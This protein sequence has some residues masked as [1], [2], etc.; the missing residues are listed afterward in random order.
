MSGK[1][2]VILSLWHV[3]TT[4]N[5]NT[6]ILWKNTQVITVSN[7]FWKINTQEKS[8]KRKKTDNK[9]KRSKI[10][11]I[12][13]TVRKHNYYCNSQNCGTNIVKHGIFA[14][15]PKPAYRIDERHE[16]P[17]NHVT[18]YAD[19][20]FKYTCIFWS[21]EIS[22]YILSRKSTIQNKYC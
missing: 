22:S 6:D 9:R 16:I 13:W 4:P 1:I 5:T 11:Y 20:I 7:C 19:L 15:P 18:H 3:S 8:Y 21:S 14:P 12:K 10:N 17:M 2:M